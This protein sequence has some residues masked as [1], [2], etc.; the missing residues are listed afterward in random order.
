[1]AT[2]RIYRREGGIREESCCSE[3]NSGEE[4]ASGAYAKRFQDIFTKIRRL[5][6]VE[7]LF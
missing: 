3:S 7:A 5:M 1:M 6:L 2:A 4:L